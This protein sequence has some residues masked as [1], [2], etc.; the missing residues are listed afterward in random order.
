M[1]SAREWAV[2]TLKETGRVVVSGATGLTLGAAA[3]FFAPNTV[4]V[5][6]N[7]AT[8]PEPEAN[9]TVPQSQDTGV[10]VGLS[11]GHSASDVIPTLLVYYGL[12]AW[13]TAASSLSNV[14]HL[15]NTTFNAIFCLVGDAS[16]DFALGSL[17]DHSLGST[18]GLFA[19]AFVGVGATHLV[20]KGL[21]LYSGDTV[22]SPQ[23]PENPE[24]KSLFPASLT[25]SQQ[26]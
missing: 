25:A 18:P 20:K 4:P 23:D 17:I 16:L 11:V 15:R 21:D 9:A 12:L 13:N 1:A 14:Q 5:Q 24:R 19:T 22:C 2:V 7:N 8:F 26:D 3:R 10:R 6:T